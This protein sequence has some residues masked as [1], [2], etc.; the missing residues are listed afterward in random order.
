M[1]VIVTVKALYVV[2]A[3]TTK[4]FV[5]CFYPKLFGSTRCF[6]ILRWTIG[7][8]T[9]VYSSVEFLM[10]ILQVSHAFD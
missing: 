6:T 8:F 3:A 9:V 4:F 10:A 7:M 5:L 1:Q 2:E